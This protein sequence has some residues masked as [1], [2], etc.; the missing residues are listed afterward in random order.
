[1][2]RYKEDE[3]RLEA[4]QAWLELD[5]LITTVKMRQRN[6]I[7]EL[8]ELNAKLPRMLAGVVKG[9]VTRGEVAAHKARMAELREVVQEAPI[10]IDELEREKTNGCLMPLQ[11]A[12]S[13]SKDRS[14]YEE[15][16]EAMLQEGSP[17]RVEELWQCARRIGE[18]ED[19]ERFLE[20]TCAG[21]GTD[22]SNGGN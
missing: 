22:K 20:L 16:K 5:M 8:N 10:I 3:I 19:C 9:V 12:C 18:E 4:G 14:R 11:T 17:T 1:M 7:R 15:L 21:P 13:L 2:R 6:A